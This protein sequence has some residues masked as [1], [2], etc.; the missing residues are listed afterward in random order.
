MNAML[1]GCSPWPPSS[2]PAQPDWPGTRLP[3]YRR[4]RRRRSIVH[5]LDYVSVDYPEFVRDGKVTNPA[6]YEEQKEFVTQAIALLGQLPAKPETPGLLDKARRLL[7]RVDAKAAGPEVAALANAVRADVIRVYQLTVAPR[8]A[9]DLGRAATMYEAQCASCHGAKG[10]GD[11]PLAK[12]MEPAPRNFHDEDRMA[13]RSTYG[14]YNTISLGVGGTTMRG[15]AELS[16]A[17]RWGLAF[18]VSGLRVA[19]EASRER[20]VALESGNGPS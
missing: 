6:E 8:Q 12:G 13:A 9:P 10:R 16:E 4:S 17:D 7:A 19:P 14:M 2:F 15:F 11:G 1:H 3:P 18:L 20:R 5:M